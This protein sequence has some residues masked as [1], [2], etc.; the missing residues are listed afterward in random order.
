MIDRVRVCL[1]GDESAVALLK[2]ARGDLKPVAMAATLPATGAL[3]LALGAEQGAPTAALGAVS[4][5]RGLWQSMRGGEID[6]RLELDCRLRRTAEGGLAVDAAGQPF[7]MTVLGPRRR[8]LVIPSVTIARV[9]ARLER[10]MQEIETLTTR[11]T[12]LEQECEAL[13]QRE[14]ARLWE[15]ESPQKAREIAFAGHAWRLSPAH[16]RAN[17]A[18]LRSRVRK[19]EPPGSFC[20]SATSEF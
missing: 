17:G 15:R 4:V 5:S 12:A 6:A 8:V 14:L 3:A 10:L 13:R 19:S 9:A 20:R 18:S 1:V 11:V 2:V 16:V 7:G